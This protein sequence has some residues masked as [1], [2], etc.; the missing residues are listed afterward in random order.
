MKRMVLVIGGILIA[1]PI[2]WLIRNSRAVTK[3]TPYK[4]VRTDG[5]VEVRDYPGLTLATTAMDD[6][7][8]SQAFMRLFGF[9]SGKNAKEQ[10]IPMTTPVVIDEAS[11]KPTMS[12]V[13]PQAVVEK[14]TPEPIGDVRLRK[15][16]PG[17]Y[18]VLRFKDD[19]RGPAPKAAAD[20]L[21]A[22]LHEHNISAESEPIFAYYDPPWTP[23]FLRRNEVMMRIASQYP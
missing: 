12:F 8:S 6:K 9:I 11:G 21:R 14:G 23:V 17:R 10:Q 15:M 18:A 13:L 7:E 20:R 1:L 4:L 5:P 16:Q 2:A 22:W 3:T 19:R